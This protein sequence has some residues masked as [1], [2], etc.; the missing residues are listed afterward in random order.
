MNPKYT[1]H[2]TVEYEYLRDTLEAM[3]RPLVIQAL[4]PYF[5]LPIIALL[6]LWRGSYTLGLVILVVSVC[7][8]ISNLTSRKR[9]IN[10]V[11]KQ[12]RKSGDAKKMHC[13]VLLWKDQLSLVCKAVDRTYTVDFSSITR[14]SEQGDYILFGG[15]NK[16]D[17]ILPKKDFEKVPGAMEYLRKQCNVSRET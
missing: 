16:F 9:Y 1:V 8:F 3:V 2:T 12:I 7:I 10:R 13:K 17:A 14:L 15:Y 6:V 11:M 5:I 4:I